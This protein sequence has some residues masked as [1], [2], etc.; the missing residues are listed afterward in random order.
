MR[1][2]S[3]ILLSLMLALTSLSL[4][5][6]RGTSPDFGVDI[7]ICT[8][9]GVTTITIGPDGEPVEK[10]VLCPDSVS[11]FAATFAVPAL[12][13]PEARL[14]DRVDP[15]VATSL[16]AQAELSPSARGPPVLV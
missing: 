14:A 3:G 13:T 1:V 12:A 11:L 10:T 9:V 6:A 8:G 5:S 2:V 15:V 16:T 4:A 7:A